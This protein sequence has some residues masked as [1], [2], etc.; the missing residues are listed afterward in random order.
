MEYAYTPQCSKYVQEQFTSAQWFPEPSFDC[1]S[2]IY[3]SGWENHSNF[4]WTQEPL[5]QCYASSSRLAF[6]NS[7]DLCASYPTSLQQPYQHQAPPPP[8]KYSIDFQEKML[9]AFEEFRACKQERTQ[10]LHSQ[11]QSLSKIE[12]YADQIEIAISGWEEKIVL[13]NEQVVMDIEH[14]EAIEK[15]VDMEHVVDEEYGEDKWEMEKPIPTFEDSR[16]ERVLLSNESVDP[17]PPSLSFTLET[18]SSDQIL[19]VQLEVLPREFVKNNESNESDSDENYDTEAM[20]LFTKN[21]K[22]F[23]KKKNND[24]DNNDKKGKGKF[25]TSSNKDR[26]GVKGPPSGPKCYECHGYGHLAQD[27]ANKKAKQKIFSVTTWDDDTNSE[28][29]NSDR[30]EENNEKNFLAFT[31]NHHES[32]MTQ[33]KLGNGGTHD[34]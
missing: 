11:S 9:Q 13:N 34:I 19:N 18:M 33:Q 29:S 23:F 14:E 6:S 31:A 25:E 28:K 21:F 2:N 30:D 5:N 26:K 27:C 15:V 10:L 7:F 4:T 24:S 22:R 8:Q 16:V 32:D 3:N 17:S 20:A 1:Y 12:A